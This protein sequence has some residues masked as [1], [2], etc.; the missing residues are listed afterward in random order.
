MYG[1]ICIDMGLL[2]TLPHQCL[3]HPCTELT[4]MLSLRLCV[5]QPTPSSAGFE[6]DFFINPFAPSKLD[7]YLSF[8]DRKIVTKTCMKHATYFN[9]TWRTLLEQLV[10]TP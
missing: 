7:R 6:L 10:E 4:Y 5:V 3:C 8:T 9:V 1:T 2:D